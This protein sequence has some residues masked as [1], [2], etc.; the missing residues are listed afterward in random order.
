DMQ[1]LLAR[2]VAAGVRAVALEASSHA[3]AQQRLD[4][5]VVDVAMFTNLSRDHL[6]FHPTMD[7]YFEAKAAL[8]RATHARAGVVNADDAWG[9]RLLAAST[10]PITTYGLD[11]NADV[12]ATDLVVGLGGIGFDAAGVSVRSGLR[13]RFNASNCLGAFAAGLALGI[14]PGVIARGIASVGTV[15]GRMEPIEAGQPFAVVVDYA[16]TPDS[17]LGVLRGARALAAGQVIVVFGCGGDRD[18]AKR[19]MMGRAATG[20]ADL[21]IVTSDNPRHED[22]AVI[23]D[24]IV[25]GIPH[26]ARYVVE[27]DR[28][29]AIGAA[30]AAAAPGD[31]VVIAGKGHETTQTIG[32]DV[33]PFDDRTVARDAI[34]EAI[35]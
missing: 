29:R 11:A 13:G 10:I 21:T 5:V 25:A 15:P 20:S 35:G 17:I 27:P 2:M 28:R 18:R 19:P 31:I 16:H 22:P 9:H 7:A 14:A 34:A 24:E 1:R 4:G 30:V 26:G 32:D 8:F 6:D 12:R 23:I 33:Q 3:L